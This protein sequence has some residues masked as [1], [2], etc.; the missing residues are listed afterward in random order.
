[1]S[2]NVSLESERN[3]GVDLLRIVS[4]FM[5]CVIH[6]NVWTRAHI[7]IIPTK[8]F[9]FYFATWTEALGIIGVNLYALISGYVCV[10]S[11]WRFSRYFRLWVMV[12]FY[13][14]ALALIGVVFYQMGVV[15]VAIGAQSLL[16]WGR[17]LLFGSTYWYFVAYSGMFFL[18][19]FINDALIS[20]SKDKYQCLILVLVVLLPIFNRG[21]TIPILS[22][23]YNMIWLI[24]LYVVG[25]YI[26]LYP[27]SICA[28]ILLLISVFCASMTVLM[29]A[30]G[31]LCDNLSYT[32]P[33]NVI[34]AISLFVVFARL[35]ISSCCG[36]KMV[37][38]FAP[39]AF[40]V[41]LIQ[42]HPWVWEVF[43]IEMMELFRMLDYP[44]WFSLFFGV[45]LYLAASIVDFARI[46]L[47]RLCRVNAVSDWVAGGIERMVKK[48]M[49]KLKRLLE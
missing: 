41:Y 15:D 11:K 1:M 10:C 29:P 18:I 45:V 24:M 9:V 4:M 8:E 40:S 39:A 49:P 31:V 23:G 26:R 43:E 25:A 12:A 20:L 27:I 19:P 22:S 7:Q 33:N 30:L 13:T 36:R 47:F 14:I 28:S 38:Y 6:M 21:D 35:N 34:Y 5:V 42:C 46:A 17:L 16:V 37:D 44:W 2:Q 48:L 3:Y 32:M